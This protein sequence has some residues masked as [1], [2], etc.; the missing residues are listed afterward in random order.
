MYRTTLQY[1]DDILEATDKIL[2]FGKGVSFEEFSAD[3]MRVD[4]VIRNF[5]VIGE[6]IKKLPPELT[7]FYPGIDWK[8]IAGLRDAL[9]HGY[10]NVKL[11]VL[12]N[13]MNDYLPKLKIDIKIVL[14]DEEKRE[15]GRKD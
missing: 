5:E 7:E 14:A 13:I 8:R 6:A 2:K 11:T 9:I 15:S 1:L 4:A 10:F 12:W 3:E